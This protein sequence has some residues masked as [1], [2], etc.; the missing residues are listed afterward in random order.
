MTIYQPTTT[1][2]TGIV[3]ENAADTV[4]TYQV[5][6]SFSMI[7]SNAIYVIYMPHA[8]APTTDAGE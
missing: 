4:R 5:T 3:L 8:D 7:G 1:T 6:D 2:R